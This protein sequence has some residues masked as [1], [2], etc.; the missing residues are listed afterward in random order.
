MLQLVEKFEQ[1]KNQNSNEGASLTNGMKKGKRKSAYCNV[2]I[3]N[4]K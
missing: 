1:A 4:R 3:K 2:D